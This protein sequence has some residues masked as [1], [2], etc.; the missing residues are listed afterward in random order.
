LEVPK[1]GSHMTTIRSWAEEELV[2]A[3]TEMR[4]RVGQRGDLESR[5]KH[6]RVDRLIGDVGRVVEREDGWVRDNDEEGDRSTDGLVLKP[7]TVEDVGERYLW[8]HG[9]QWLLMSGTTVSA[10]GQAE[11]LGLEEAGIPWASVEVPMLFPR[12]NRRVVYAP[13]A[14]MTRKGQEAGGLDV[15]KRGVE[16]VLQMHPEVNVLIH[17]HTYLL[18]KEFAAWCAQVDARPVFTYTDAY[19][20]EDAL[21]KFKARAGKGGAILVASSMDRGVDLPGDLCRVQ[22][23]VKVPMASLGS[24]QVSERLRTRGGQLWYAMETVRSVMQMC[25]RAVRGREDWAVTYVLDSHFGKLLGEGKKMGLFPQWWL[26]GLELG[27][28]GE[29]R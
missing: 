16:R 8:K 28:M 4:K 3:L 5:R 15:V 7:V 12:E 23:I 26:D 17:T 18:A 11:A 27:R 10:E 20:R 2:P 25:G 24:R 21:A 6:T 29:F 13:L 14:S 22:V 19:G 1:K 9:E